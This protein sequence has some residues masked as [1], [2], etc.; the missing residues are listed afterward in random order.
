MYEFYL[1]NKARGKQF[2]LDHF[3]AENIPQSTIYRIIKR[4]E[5]ESGH[6]RKLGSG[7]IAKVMTKK[8]VEKL[9]RM[10]DHKDAISQR[11][12][13]REFNCS[14]KHI[15]RTLLTKTKIRARKKIR[16]PKRSEQQKALAQTKCSRLFQKLQNRSCV[17]DDES[18]FTLAHTS[19]NGNDQFYTSNVNVTPANV[20]YQP[21]EKFQKKTARLDSFF[22]EWNHGALLCA[23]RA[24]G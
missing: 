5:N 24:C 11:Q 20:K 8:A 9:K 22:R 16:I 21:I 4:A 15:C 17:M 7:R 3:S 13:A 19:I 18:Y 6:Q 2:T 23:K 1:K 14:Q 10:F 12:A